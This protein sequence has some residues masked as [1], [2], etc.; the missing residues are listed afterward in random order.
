VKDA[1]A[2]F[3]KSSAPGPSGL[4]A[5]HLQD[6]L[7][8]PGRGAPLVSAI[9]RFC[10]MWAHG[11]IPEEMAPVLCG[12]NLTPLRKK[13]GGVRPIAVGEV[14][15][16]LA[17]KTLLSTG[18]AKEEV[19]LLSPEQVGVG[20]SRG[21]E[22]VALGFGSLLGCMGPHAKGWAQLQVDVSAAFP[23]VSRQHVLQE[24]TKD[25]PSL[26][27]A[28]KFSLSRS[29]PVYC[30]DKILYAE[31]GVP[32]GCPL[33]P[34]AFSL[35]IQPILRTISKSMGLIWNVWYLDDGLMVGDPDKLGE[36]L[37]FL[38]SELLKRGLT[39]NRKKCALWGPAAHAVPHSDNIPIIAWEPDSGITLL[40]API[41]FPGSTGH[42]EKEWDTRLDTLEETTAIVS[43]L[44][45]KQLAHHLLRHC[46]DG[47]KVT[48]L[49]RVSDPYLVPLQ[50]DRA[51][52]IV[53]SAFEDLVGCALSQQQR[54]QASL[55]L[56][57]GGCG[58]KSPRLIQP[59]A[60][61][62]ALLSYLGGGCA[63]VAVPTYART[64]SSTAITPVLDD[65]TAL[66]GPQFESLQQWS[67]K[68]ALLAA[69]EPAKWHQKHWT[70]AIGKATMIRL[71]DKAGSRDQA[72]L[73]EQ[74]SG[75]GTSWMSVTPS[76][77]LRTI[78]SSE[79]YSLALKWWLGLPLFL[80]PNTSA[81]SQAAVVLATCLGITCYAVHGTI[82]L[83]DT[84]PYKR[85]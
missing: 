18:V 54:D 70:D 44:A 41:P 21:A 6:A 32:Q 77:P 81:L 63:N 65:L 45:D 14:L 76:A 64:P 84:M 37:A 33:A 10:H 4:R 69:A 16:R 35:A 40:G 85:P 25:A 20:V 27:N 51:N 30:G 58:L 74:A 43:S 38:E 24:T 48:Y 59:A 66:L 78:I 62:A 55:P 50:T 67:G 53:M 15:R 56:S 23:T 17:C 29:S 82:S 83:G 2:S 11:L 71:L 57:A 31:T 22:S 39:L 52:D 80:G 73:L 49:F 79:D 68:H 26:Y 9:A 34:V 36:A 8:R 72:R 46:L 12:A 42:L 3:P 61:I 5:S 28:L 47:C 19:S 7:R 1:I 75:L 13:D 60:R